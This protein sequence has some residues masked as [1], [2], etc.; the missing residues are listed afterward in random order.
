MTDHPPIHALRTADRRRGHGRL[1]RRSAVTLGVVTV[2]SIVAAFMVTAASARADLTYTVG[3][4]NR[5]T[6]R[7]LLWDDS[8][9]LVVRNGSNTCRSSYP[10]VGTDWVLH[11]WRDGSIQ[12]R[13]E[14]VG[15]APC[16]DDRVLQGLRL[17]RCYPGWSTDSRFQSWFRVYVGRSY[18]HGYNYYALRNQATGRCLDDSFIRG[19]RTHPCKRHVFQSWAILPQP[20]QD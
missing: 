19:I 15:A 4:K 20:G 11:Q 17:I 1:T 18:L 2:V 16:L 14:N 10:W 12:L 7:C 6:G 8:W 9:T 13:E 5:A 3:L